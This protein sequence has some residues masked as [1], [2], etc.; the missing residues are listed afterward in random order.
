MSRWEREYEREMDRLNQERTRPSE[1]GAWDDL[2]EGRNVDRWRDEP[3]GYAP[4]QREYSDP[5]DYVD[6][7]IEPGHIPYGC[8]H[9]TNPQ[10]RRDCQET[11]EANNPNDRLWYGR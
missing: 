9:I 7:H 8:G 6:G 4:G 2:V 10:A 5:Q 1:R 11:W 3:D